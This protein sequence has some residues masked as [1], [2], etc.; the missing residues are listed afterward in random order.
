MK[1]AVVGLTVALGE[2]WYFR[3]VLFRKKTFYL[4]DTAAQEYPLRVQSAKRGFTWQW[5]PYI[6][7]GFPVLGEGLVAPFYPLHW[8]FFAARSPK[9][10]KYVVYTHY[11]M[12]AGSAYLLARQRRL[13]RPGATLMAASFM[14]SGFL[15]A[16]N[17]VKTIMASATWDPLITTASQRCGEE[18]G[19]PLWFSIG[20]FATA[21]QLTTGQL[22]QTL[23]LFSALFAR[24]SA[25]LILDRS[26]WPLHLRN[27]LL[28][29]GMVGTG[30]LLAL[31]Q[32]VPMLRLLRESKRVK[33]VD[34][35]QDT[36][37][38]ATQFSLPPRQLLTLVFPRMFGTAQQ[39]TYHGEIGPDA[40]AAG[41]VGPTVLL[42]AL[43]ALVRRQNSATAG[44]AISALLA[45][46]LS[47]GKYT[48]L[49]RI[50]Y[51]LL[52]LR[53]FRGP[54]RYNSV[55]A[56]D[57]AYLAGVGLEELLKM[58]PISPR[59]ISHNALMGSMVSL[60]I[61]WW[62]LA[63]PLTP[64]W[65]IPSFARYLQEQKP[66]ALRDKDEVQ[67]R[68]IYAEK[69]SAIKAGRLHDLRTAG[70]AV[71][72]QVTA[73][74]L[75]GRG[76]LSNQQYAAVL[77]AIKLLEHLFGGFPPFPT[78]DE[79]YYHQPPPGIQRIIDTTTGLFRIDSTSAWR[80]S[81]ERGWSRVAA[82]DD[83]FFM[84]G[85]SSA[86]RYAAFRSLLGGNMSMCFDIQNV[87]G[88]YHA[89]ELG[90]Y[91][92]VFEREHVPMH[93]YEMFNVV[94]FLTPEQVVNDRL[95]LF[96]AE[97]PVYIYR[98][99]HSLPRAWFAS[100]IIRAANREH[101]LQLLLSPDFQPRSSVIVEDD[102]SAFTPSQED[103]MSEVTIARY[104]AEYVCLKVHAPCPGIVIL[105]DSFN[106]GWHGYLNGVEVPILRC[107]YLLRGI[108]VESGSSTIE[109]YYAEPALPATLAVS[110]ATTLSLIVIGARQRRKE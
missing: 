101:A 87:G 110:L 73:L 24:Q 18:K 1:K 83:G 67:A 63:R 46:L 34:G 82:W 103:V 89:L 75:R 7:G 77:V 30:A 97:P 96:Y 53:F 98:N 71:L 55:F 6:N 70:L 2:A 35:S 76:T 93:I 28:T 74:L 106:T 109:F 22:H 62:F 48:P 36:Y 12:A 58:P 65:F 38:A 99:N 79:K 16:F 17:D 23:V 39:L 56:L 8:P 50:A 80:G 94:Y 108:M 27:L 60:S 9:V 49:Y 13:S 86:H 10:Y 21:C 69:V 43:V 26:R 92:D 41:Y 19:S 100:R 95:T 11:I 59:H 78:V 68:A 3:K 31:P 45:L 57:M 90:R 14:S 29:G 47:M 72:A 44:T 54:Y 51:T 85:F 40:L 37:I 88:Y 15:H 25:G 84:P 105:C 107:N 32:L 64:S 52:P 33:G 81:H 102:T 4:F 5:N 61:A 91:V 104:E 20:S 42:L 66:F